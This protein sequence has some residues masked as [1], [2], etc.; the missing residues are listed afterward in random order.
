MEQVFRILAV[1][2]WTEFLWVMIGLGG[3]LLFTAR[4]LVQWIASERARRS[5]VPLAFWY[6]S[7]GG[8]F[9]L[10]AYAVYRKDPVFI[11]GQSMGVFIY[12]R[13]LWLI[14]AERRKIAR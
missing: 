5:V 10:F 4:F 3:Q 9:I 6:L 13:N 1:S 2:N 7:I 14:H 12:C 8:G 11:L